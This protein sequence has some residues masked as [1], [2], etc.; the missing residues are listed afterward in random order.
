MKIKNILFSF[1][2]HQRV[3]YAGFGIALL[4][5]TSY[6]WEPLNTLALALVWFTLITLS[7]DALLLYVVRNG[8]KVSRALNLRFSNGDEN[9]V[10]LN[11]ANHYNY[12]IRCTVVDGIPYQFQ[13]RDWQRQITLKSEEENKIAYSLKPVERG[14]YEFGKIHVFVSSPLQL[15]QR[16]YQF[17]HPQ[18]VKVY[19]SF[20]QMRRYQLLAI[21]N[22]LA[23]AGTKKIRRLGHSIEFEQIKEYVRGD[24]YRT[25]NWKATARR[26]DF[27]VN[28]FTDER[29][30]QIFCLVN[31]SRMMKMPFDGMTLLDHAINTALVLLN[32]AIVKGDKAGL[33]TYAQTVD[34][35]LPADKKPGQLN[36]ILEALYQQKTRFLEPDLEALFSTVR[37]RIS[38]RSLLIL[39]TNYETLESLK[40]DLSF[41]KKLA[42]YHLLMV[43]FFENTELQ[44]LT[45]SKA[46]TI[47]DIYIKTIA[48]KYAMEKK[49]M[50]KE[51][52]QLGIIALLSA[53]QN[54][55]VNTLNKYLELKNRQSI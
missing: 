55:T 9:E 44:E 48:Q 52:Q 10:V 27:M 26:G 12:T 34:T 39:F 19:P 18:K 21:G 3:Y 25:L 13:E 2:V 45:E 42:H 36:Q 49:L 6:F 15:V 29:S 5:A 50:V 1:Y 47:E 43:V 46:K 41:Y 30:Q 7:I 53:P 38:Q 35:Y 4:F 22:R 24:D 20:V 14:V 32:V 16:R 51:L 37:N 11:L 8:V 33:I 17:N 28:T 23:E 54:L 40:R 31:K